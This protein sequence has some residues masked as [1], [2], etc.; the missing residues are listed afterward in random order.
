MN[1][2]ET[3]IRY[4]KNVSNIFH[5]YKEDVSCDVLGNRHRLKVYVYSNNNAITNSP[6]AVFIELVK[7]YR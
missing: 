1:R 2:F 5:Y 7:K 3:I 4:H 6:I